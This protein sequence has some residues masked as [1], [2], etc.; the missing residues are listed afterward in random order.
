AAGW[1]DPAPARQRLPARARSGVAGAALAARAAHPLRRRPGDLLLEA[2]PSATGTRG[3]RRRAD[4]ARPASFRAEDQDRHA[5]GGRRGLR[6]SRLPLQT[7]AKPNKRQAVHRLLAEPEGGRGGQTADPR[8]HPARTDW[9]AGDRRRAGHQPLPARVERVLPLRQLGATAARARPLRLLAPVA[10]PHT[11]VRQ[12]RP[13][14]RDGATA[15]VA[16]PARTHPP[17]RNRPLQH[18]ACRTVNDVGEPCEG[19]PHARFDGGREETSATRSRRLSPTLLIRHSLKYAPRRER[20][21]VARDLKPIYTPVDADAAQAALEAFDD[22]WGARFPVITQ[23]WLNAWEYVT[24][25][26]AFPDEV[27]RV[28]YTTDE[29]VKSADGGPG[30][31]I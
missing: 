21:Q 8:P 7:R 5:G 27:R 15:R 29:K 14:T 22:T 10:L 23:A 18:S 13:P 4:R 17:H 3:A 2:G 19:E 16:Q 24:P 9:P 12:D 30:A 20:E 26:L 1:G 28:V 31:R 25:F 6:L 11:E